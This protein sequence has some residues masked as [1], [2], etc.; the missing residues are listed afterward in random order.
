MWAA[1]LW[2]VGEAVGSAANHQAAES[3][4]SLGKPQQW[5]LLFPIT[6][7]DPQSA[8]AEGIWP[9]CYNP[10]TILGF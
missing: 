2:F 10:A 5:N 3:D 4:S 6:E 9:K 8:T 7:V 1:K